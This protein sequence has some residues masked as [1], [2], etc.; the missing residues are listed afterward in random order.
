MSMGK[1]EEK[2]YGLLV[3]KHLTDIEDAPR[4]VCYRL[5]SE[6]DIGR[7]IEPVALDLEFHVGAVRC[8]FECAR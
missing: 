3:G 1:G 2:A 8:V 7:P 6:G 5:A 4:D